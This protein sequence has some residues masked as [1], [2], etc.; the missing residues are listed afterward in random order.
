MPAPSSALLGIV[1]PPWALL[2]G[3]QPLDRSAVQE[4]SSHLP[5]H[6]E[7]LGASVWAIHP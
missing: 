1:L 3:N 2:L 6:F 5:G 4:D 7:M